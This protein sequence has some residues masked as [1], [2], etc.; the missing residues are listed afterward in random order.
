MTNKRTTT[1]GDV[2]ICD[3]DGLSAIYMAAKD[4]RTDCLKLLLAAGGDVNKCINDGRSPIY[5]AA[6]YGHAECLQLLLASRA[7]PRS[8][9]K[10]TSALE[11]SRQKKLAECVRVLEAA[12]A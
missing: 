11:R 6:C 2:S 10:G 9:W 4:G 8:S 7:D 3:N 1:G 12:L 5:I